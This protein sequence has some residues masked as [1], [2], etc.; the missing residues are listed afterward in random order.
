MKPEISA[1]KIALLLAGLFI[2]GCSITPVSV[3]TEPDLVGTRIAQAAEKASAALDS[4][5]GI[6][7][8]RSPLPPV[9]DYSTAPAGMMQP[10]TIKWTGPIEQITQMLANRAGLRFRT[11]GRPPAVPLTV[12]VDVYQKPLV[13]VLR[14]VGLQAGQRADVNVDGQT[15][16]VEIRYAPADRI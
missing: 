12:V 13:E 2:A 5:S 15:G 7:Q 10:I 8:Q 1:K 11:S 6:E 14:S 4:I 16:V 9:E 3:A